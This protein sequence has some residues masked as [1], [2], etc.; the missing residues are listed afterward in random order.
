MGTQKLH[1]KPSATQPKTSG[2]E[3]SIKP[4]EYRLTGRQH[5]NRKQTPS[6]Q[7][8][9]VNTGEGCMQTVRCTSTEP[10]STNIPITTHTPTRS[11]DKTPPNKPHP[12][13]PKESKDMDSSDGAVSAPLSMESTKHT[14]QHRNVWVKTITGCHRPRRETLGT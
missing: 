8:H 14:T 6:A 12:K 11:Q 5:R 13:R 10:V 2:R 7:L 1:Q 3:T 9:K 4:R